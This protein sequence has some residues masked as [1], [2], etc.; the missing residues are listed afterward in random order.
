MRFK[1]KNQIPNRMNTTL[2]NI[3]PVNAIIKIDIVKDDYATIVESSLKKF[4]QRAEIPGFRKGMVPM[5][6]VKK[7]YGES[8]LVDEINKLISEKLFSYIKENDLNILGEPLPNETE[9]KEINFQTQED[10]EFCFDIALAPELKIELNKRDKLVYNE[11]DI[12]D[13]LLNKQIESQ[14]ANH[15]S[16][17]QVDEFSGKD[18]L[19]GTLTEWEA[20]A[21]KADGLQVEDAVMMPSYIKNEEEKAKFDHAK[22]GDSIVFNPSVAYEGNEAEISSFL[23]IEKEEIGKYTGEFSIEIAE[24]THYEEAEMNQDFFNKVYPSGEVTTEEEFKEKVR[25]QI[26]EQYAPNSDYLFMQEIHKLFEKKAGNIEFPD[27]FL[28]RWLLASNKEKTAETLEEE[29]PKIIEDL[30][31]HLIKE[32][33]VKENNFQLEDNDVVTFAK[34][35]ARAQFAQ[36]GM[37]SVPDDIL[38]NYAQDMLKNK[39]AV[40]NIID[41]AMEDKLIAWIKEKV[42]IDTKTL[43]LAEYSKLFE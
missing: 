25:A 24:I 3:D 39:D 4:R 32:Q 9:Q 36:Y 15:G 19:K 12:D 21:A 34:R 27:A 41:K 6:M 20:G 40:R 2:K 18:M 22:K 10:F 37:M 8:V 30:K 35:I 14:K 17:T 29:Y 23:K 13:E 1:N 42:K 7:L 33:I 38:E 28:K 31:F 11:V 43:P 5:G 16:Y 26:A